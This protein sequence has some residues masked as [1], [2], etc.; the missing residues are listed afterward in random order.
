MEIEDDK[1]LDVWQNIEVGLKAAYERE[2]S[3]TDAL[4]I[5]AL[6][7]AKI[8]V[9]K[10]CGF[11]KNEKVTAHPLAKEIVDWCVS[12]GDAR[13]GKVNDLTLREYLR[14]IERVRRSVKLHSEFGSRS[15]YE[16]IRDYV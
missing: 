5:F 6:E 13:I 9:K 12:V 4:C 1:Y 2:G 7:N 3:L 10:H 11:A 14:C 8:A 16:F 15:Y